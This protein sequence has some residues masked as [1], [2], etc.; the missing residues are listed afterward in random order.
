MGGNTLLFIATRQ[1]KMTCFLY[2]IAWIVIF[3]QFDEKKNQN[4]KKSNFFKANFVEVGKNVN[5]RLQKWPKQHVQLWGKILASKHDNRTRKVYF[6]SS[7]QYPLWDK[8]KK[9]FKICAHVVAMVTRKILGTP[10]FCQK[11]ANFGMILMFYCKKCTGYYWYHLKIQN[12]FFPMI[13]NMPYALKCTFLISAALSPWP[14][15]YDVTLNT[16]ESILNK[17]VI[18][19]RIGDTP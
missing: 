3:F 15:H 10:L 18:S 16:V 13:Y 4:F 12:L 11:I 9:Y 8:T 17:A 19:H 2:F 6:F 5:I 1:F 7:G 14:L